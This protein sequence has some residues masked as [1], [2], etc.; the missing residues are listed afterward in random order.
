MIQFKKALS[1]VIAMMLFV[2]TLS[3]EAAAL[4]AAL[5]QSSTLQTITAGATLENIS[6][7]TLNGWLNINVLRIDTTNPNIRIDTLTND[8]ITEKLVTVPA[9]A[10]QD[11]AVAAVNAS[12]FNAINAGTGYADGPI[13]QDG[14]L[15]STAGW[16]N[17]N[18]NEM[19]SLSLSNYGELSIDYWK[20]ELQLIGPD[21]APFVVSQYNQPS[22]RNYTDIT[23]LDKKWG[24]STLGASAAYPDLVEVLVSDGR[25][26]EVRQA[27]SAA[28]IPT[29][30]FVI[31][32]RGEQAA[33]LVQSL[34]IGGQASLSL[35][36]TPDWSG[37]QMSVTGAS[38]LVRDGQIPD[39][40]SYNVSSFNQSNPRTLAGSTQDGK[41]L[42]LVTVD[43][44]QDNSIG[45]TQKESAELMLQLGAYN[46]MIL[47]GGGSTT[48]VARTPG[49]KQLQV[50]NVPSEGTLR[51]VANAIG[52]F[53]LA[54]AGTLSRLI[55]ETESPNVFVNTSRSFTL[56]GV[57][58]YAN[59]VD[60][61]PEDVKWGVSGIKGTFT[62]STLRPTSVG[63]GKVTAKV[64]DLTA[65]L[66]ICSLSAPARLILSTNESKLPSGQSQTIQVTGCSLEGFTARI[67]PEDIQ[68][69]V[70][71]SIGIGDCLNGVFQ[72][73]NAGIGYIE[74]S[75][76]N[77]HAYCAVA[78]SSEN[79]ENKY[80]FE[81]S[82]GTFSAS[83]ENVRG[84]YRI[85][86][87]QVY[88]GQTSGEL[89]YDF[90]YTEDPGEASVLFGNK[91]VPLNAN[92]SGLAVWV[93]NSLENTN[94]LMGEI[95]D[96]NGKK[97]QVQFS[98]DMSW[99]GWRQVSTSLGSIN[100]PRYL[101]RLYV[102]NTDP[103]NSGGVI[104]WDELTA[105]VS[106][107]PAIDTAKIPQNTVLT[108]KANRAATFS[109]GSSNFRFAVFGSSVQPSSKSKQQ[110]LMQLNTFIN[111][112]MDLAI[113][114]G[115]NAAKL[116]G[117]VTKPAMKTGSGYKTFHYKNSTFIQLD[118]CKGG[119]RRT[120]PAQ[121]TS[122]FKEL[123]S[124]KGDQIFVS[125]DCA[126]GSFV[127]A[128]EAALLKDTLAD[129]H[130]E[131][132]KNVYVFYP[133]STDQVQLDRG[134]R[135]ISC[136]GFNTS[137]AGKQANKLIVT[138]QGDQVTYEFKAL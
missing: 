64:G 127:N 67:Q 44:R 53:S 122:L 54:P 35:N 95:I 38:I 58:Q 56:K 43:G 15:L 97:H 5:Y 126:P 41:Q 124:S 31:I 135:Y 123:N 13:V 62:G 65:E 27:Q 45:L 114:T 28:A 37:L 128:K 14:S 12:F 75:V 116:A 137:A 81:D 46:A 9:L 3:S 18:K 90:L 91:G 52:I 22:R 30:G 111:K 39:K 89:M 115:A 71:G 36:S 23:V 131:T 100:S 80:A 99:N 42:I 82:F 50:A 72:A 47:D 66:D 57:D 59:P 29:N 87:G 86:S 10:Q 92:T 11:N 19:A 93:Y 102:R 32:S 134:V 79:A 68:W 125:M 20:N 24:A 98:A 40:F 61:D 48:M 103:S 85:S 17:Q 136:A 1:V 8:Q 76:G 107:H 70:Y 73:Q 6:R 129:Y 104:Y 2:A 4:P 88:A 109:A 74:A 63:D 119:L 26:V 34:Q 101:T 96:A 113:Y 94:K 112:N 130:K 69:K 33:E 121:W 49:T 108:D 78:V 84:S 133:G 132:G 120:D 25:V 51:P 83:S 60:I 138:V 16:Y 7:F 118:C 55:I 106:N 117:G 110:S 77:A 105:S 21:F